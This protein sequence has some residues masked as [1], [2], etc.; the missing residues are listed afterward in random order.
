V[1]SRNGDPGRTPIIGAFESTFL[2]GHGVDVSETSQHSIRWR[3]DLDFDIDAGV[4]TFRYPLRWHR[5]ESIPGRHDWSEP[6][7][8]L[9]YLQDRGVEVALDLLHHTS[10]PAW[11]TDGLRDC[12]FAE[13]YVR[14]A[15]AVAQRYPHVGAYTLVNEP[16][17]TLFLAGH[18]AL[19]PPYDQGV[20][21]FARLLGNVLPAVSM[22][23]E[24]WSA[25]LPEAQ[26]LWVDTAEYHRG[27]PGSPARHAAM[28][29]G[30][31]HAVLDLALGRGLDA[32]QTFTAELLE[33]GIDDCLAMAPI[34]V[35]V[36]GLDYYSHSEWWYDHRGAHAPS[37]HPVGF[38]A[39]A[40]QYAARYGLPMILGET[41]VRGLP[42]DRVS[43]LRYMLEQ[44]EQAVAAGAPLHGFCWFPSVDSCDWDSLL[45]RPAGRRDPVG[46]RAVASDG[47]R[48]SHEFTTAWRAVVRG[49]TAADLPAYRFQPPLDQQLSGF[50]RGLD[51]WPW[52]PPSEHRTPAP[53]TVPTEPRSTM[54]VSPE[55][56]SPH[57][58]VVLSHL[59]WTWVWQRPQ[60]LVS[61]FAGLRAGSG[62]HTYF[63]EEPS[64]GNVDAPEL[65]VEEQDG[66]T[67]V[68]LV[69]PRRQDED[70]LGFDSPGT[71]DYAWLLEELLAERGSSQVDVLLYTPMALDIAE[72]LAPRCLA[73]DVMDDL[74]SFAQAPT[75]LRLRQ[76]RALSEA[77][78]VFAGGRSLQE[79]ASK[80]RHGPV[81]LFASGVEAAHY[82]VSRELRSRHDRPV[83]GYVGVLDER[84]DLTLL[85]GLA[86]SLPD[87]TI[88]AVGPVAK[89]DPGSLPQAPNLE[90][91]GMASYD[92][93]PAVMAGF[94]VALMPFALNDATRSISP[95][96]TLEYLAAGLPVVSTR[97]P[98]V[99][100]D[101][102]GVV[103]LADTAEE[104]AAACRQLLGTHGH[105][106]AQRIESV[107]ARH[108]WDEIASAMAALLDDVGRELEDMQ[109]NGTGRGSRPG[110]SVGSRAAAGGKA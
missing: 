26:H 78:V 4:R 42:S 37:P 72:H 62:C 41:N 106:G 81:H 48:N 68:W 22:A 15:E 91:P 80:H 102:T 87:W 7:T 47:T 38:A 108:E 6:D 5:I 27:T 109:G 54:T 64:A 13:A 84:L 103:H 9:A 70:V 33:A 43:W 69:V 77:D 40:Q 60:H 51:H 58:L 94:D 98:D 92:E 85:E 101:Y 89:I 32:T 96:K 88:R 104:F 19:W 11:L 45:S 29:N 63:V 95:T 52:T 100:S 28:A 12:R 74:A 21:G 99:V 25:V 39:I 105:R 75:G 31:R 44:Y 1:W 67:R 93:L 30:R 57:D 20:R 3:E 46:V 8:V 14:F 23:S 83:A 50:V 16:L 34:R 18:E 86:R 97:V 90:Y 61:R 49:A 35:D 110:A 24:C 82:A 53:L 65:A 71:D 76:R 10:Y 73:F 107:L 66:I 36:L 55:T 2:P 59:R 17:A 56:S 79:S